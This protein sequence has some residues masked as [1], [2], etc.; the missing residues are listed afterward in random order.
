MSRKEMEPIVAKPGAVVYAL[1]KDMNVAVQVV[2]CAS[3]FGLKARNFD[4]ADKLLESASTEKP[5]LVVLDF[6]HC[7]AEAYKT[8][9]NLRENAD[10]KGVPL[11]GFVTQARSAVKSEAE[12]AGC[13]R[14]YF[15]TEFNRE[16]PN[17]IMRYAK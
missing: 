13:D 7:E 10:S 17:F 15:K 14:V 1:V 2:K 6:E 16:L 8:L 9:K 4:K 11:V 3:R 12:A 5:F